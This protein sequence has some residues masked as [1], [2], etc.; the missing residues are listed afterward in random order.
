MNNMMQRVVEYLGVFRCSL[1]TLLKST[2]YDYLSVFAAFGKTSILKC[3]VKLL[4]L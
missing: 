4:G 2:D 1:Q 3:L